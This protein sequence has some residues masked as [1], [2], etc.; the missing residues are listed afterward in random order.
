MAKKQKKYSSGKA[1]ISSPAV[2]RSSVQEFNPDYTN[3]IK[4]LKTI[5]IMALS[6]TAILIILSFV[7]N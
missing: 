5:G 6:F 3:I 7:L 4:D 2:K 1:T